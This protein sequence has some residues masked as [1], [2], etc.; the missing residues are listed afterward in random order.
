MGE[1]EGVDERGLAVKEGVE[2]LTQGGVLDGIPL[3]LVEGWLGVEVVWRA[4]G[5]EKMTEKSGTM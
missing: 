4:N 2:E 5:F 1:K 3:L